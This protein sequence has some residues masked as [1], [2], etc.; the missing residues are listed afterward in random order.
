MSLLWHCDRVSWLQV[1]EGL[2]SEIEKVILSKDY[3]SQPLNDDLGGGLSKCLDLKR[4]VDSPSL[5]AVRPSWV[6]Q[7]LFLTQVSD[8]VMQKLKSACC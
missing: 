7:L 2:A 4:L 6:S 8:R 1:K 5:M 3:L